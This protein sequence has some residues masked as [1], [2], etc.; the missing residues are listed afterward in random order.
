MILSRRLNVMSTIF[1]HSCLENYLEVFNVIRYC[2]E[3][4]EFPWPGRIQYHFSSY[5]ARTR[6]RGA[7]DLLL[8]A[9]ALLPP[10]ASILV[11]EMVLMAITC[12]SF[13]NDS[14]KVVI[15]DVLI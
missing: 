11:N 1:I 6:E 5:G 8:P 10:S 3:D 9:L 4:A 7:V 12:A 15:A 14:I 13:G 2:A